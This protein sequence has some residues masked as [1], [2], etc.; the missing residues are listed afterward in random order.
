[1]YGLTETTAAVFQ[2]IRGEDN[3]LT[4]NTVGYLGDHVEAMVTNFYFDTIIF[5][6]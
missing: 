4:E 3:Q 5:F 2:S 1:M 6:K